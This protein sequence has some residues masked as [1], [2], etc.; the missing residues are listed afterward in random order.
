[1]SLKEG[2]RVWFGGRKK[3]EKMS[4]IEF[5][6]YV[7]PPTSPRST[8]PSPCSLLF[9]FPTHPGHLCCP[10]FHSRE[11]WHSNGVWLIYWG[12]T[13]RWSGSPFPNSYQSLIPLRGEISCPPSFSMLGVAW[14]CACWLNY[15]KLKCAAALLWPLLCYVMGTASLAPFTTPG[16]NSF[17]RFYNGHWASGSGVVV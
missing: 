11:G 10:Y 1:M 6:P 4:Y 3:E 12:N 15:C 9:W 5:E 8:P 13:V 2:K 14:A 7:H 16:S 17:H